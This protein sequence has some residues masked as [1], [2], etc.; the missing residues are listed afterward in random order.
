MADPRRRQDWLKTVTCHDNELQERLPTPPLFPFHF[1]A[2]D[3]NIPGHQYAAQTNPMVQT[4]D[5]QQFG[6]YEDDILP[7]TPNY[8]WPAM[9]GTEIVSSGLAAS[10]EEEIERGEDGEDD[11]EGESGDKEVSLLLHST[12]PFTSLY[13]L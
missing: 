2:L 7:G 4:F 12:V 11:G 1:P 9:Q 5:E 3:Y 10:D 8:E 6:G 13:L